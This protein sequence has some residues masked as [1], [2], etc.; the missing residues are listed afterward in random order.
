[1][2]SMQHLTAHPGSMPIRISRRSRHG[3]L[4]V[5]VNLKGLHKTTAKGITY[6]YAWRGGP[7]IK[8]EPGSRAFIKEYT[9]AIEA[10]RTPPQGTLFALIAE[11]RSSS[12]FRGKS[13]STRRAYAAYMRLIEDR[14]GD[15]PL[16]AL[17]DPA[18]RGEFK[19]WR[20]TMASNPRKADYAWTTLARILSVAKDRGRIPVNPC[21]RGGR[22]YAGDRA[23][24][25]WTEADIGRFWAAA[26]AELRLALMLAL[27][28]GQRQGDLLRLPWS[29]YDGRKITLRQSKTGASMSIPVA[30][31]LRT[32]LERTPKV[33]PLIM[34]NSHGKPWTNSGFRAS[35]RKAC[36]RSGIEGLTFH[37]LRGTAVTRLA[38]EGCSTAEIAGITGHSLKDAAMILDRHYL[39]DRAKLAENAIMR[40]ESGT[41][42]VKLLHNSKS[43]S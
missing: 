27:W 16:A 24:S 11:F 40:L 5:R 35:W 1:M 20:D 28:T 41:K 31:E 30:D 2:L 25:I 39:G 38:H 12:E 7:R 34:T 6:Y 3:K 19:S 33:G 10:R 26:G 9:D 36:A 32:M 43:S 37:D 15:M 29:G 4:A 18:V 14:F 22:L 23:D 17:S 21:E 42:S 8:S 13:D